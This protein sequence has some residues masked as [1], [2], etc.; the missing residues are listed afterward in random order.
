MTA[1]TAPRF[2]LATAPLDAGTVLL[3]ASA[4]TG[5]TYS[6]VGVLLRLLLEGHI[7]RLDR[8][9]VV[10]FTVAATAELKN[11]LRRGLLATLR[12]TRDGSDDEFLATLARQPDAAARVRAALADFDE[13][14]V[15][16]IHGF[17][18]RLL[19]DAAFESREPF[20]LEF[21]VDP[22]PLLHTAAADALRSCYSATSSLPGALLLHSG[23]DPTALVRQYSL[24]QR[25]P[26]VRFEPTAPALAARIARL[27]TAIASAV[28][29]FDDD[30]AARFPTLR[31]N[32]S[33][34]KA[35]AAI[36]RLSMPR[37]AERLRVDP[38]A[39]LAELCAMSPATIGSA[40][41][42]RPPQRLD[43]PFFAA[44]DAVRAATDDA[45]LHLRAEL[46]HRMHARLE[47]EKRQQQV[48]TFQDLL[49]RVHAALR[50][51]ER[52]PAL[53]ESVRSRFDV[54]LIDEFQDTDALQYEIFADCFAGRS[55]FLIGDPKQSIYGF[56]GADLDAYLAAQDDATARFT[57]GTNWRSA[58]GLVRAVQATCEAP[59][60]FVLDGIALPEITAHAGPDAL[61]LVGDGGAALQWRWLPLTATDD[62]GSI[63]KN[64]AEVRI[65]RD[66]AAEISRLLAGELTADGRPLS[67]R[68]IA[69]LTRTNAQAVAVQ[70]Q[71]RDAGVVSAIGK[72]GSVLE[73][74]ELDELERMLRAIL[75]PRNLGLC[76]AAMATRVFGLDAAAL[77]GLEQDEQGFEQQLER[78]EQ[79]RQ[80]WMRRGFVVM[81]EQLL[82]D[83]GVAGRWLALRGGER[84]LTNLQQLC[85]ILHRAEHEYRLSPE[86]LLEFLAHE[87]V[88]REQIDFEL[89]ELRLESDD[90]AVKILTVHGSKGLEYEV[91]F[92][93]F[94]WDGRSPA[95][96]AVVPGEQGRE[97]VFDL[98][99]SHP[100][101]LVADRERLAEDARLV[102]VALTR[103]KRRCY[104]HAGPIGFQ[105]GGMVRS[106]L[107]WMLAPLAASEQVDRPGKPRCQWYEDWVQ[108]SKDP[109]KIRAV[110]ERLVADNAEWMSLTD[111]EADPTPVPLTASVPAGRGRARRLGRKP[112]ARGLHSF[113]SLVAEALPEPVLRDVADPTGRVAPGEPAAPAGIFAFARGPAAGNCLHA[114]LEH[115]DWQ[116]LAD[117]GLDDRVRDRLREH[118]LL[119]PASHAAPIDPVAVVTANLRA[120]GRALTHPSGPPLAELCAGTTA[121]EWG[122][123]LPTDDCR[124]ATLAAT[125]A[126]GASPVAAAY[127]DRLATLPERTLRGHLVGFVDL[128]AEHDGRFW[129]I[130]WKSNH[131]GN[132][133][134]DYGDAALAGAMREHDY[135]LQYH[136]Y[137][138]ALHR[139]LRA[140]LPGY[141]YDRHFGG[142]CY[143][144]LRG[145]VP[146]SASGMFYDRPPAALV[147][148]LDG[149]AAGSAPGGDR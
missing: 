51:P 121:A 79:W 89:L 34:A 76:R 46:L 41:S 145:A 93:P 99:K 58:D 139:Q 49:T 6:V 103:A 54:G 32:Q 140:R 106:A 67:P 25:Y 95:R 87:R 130:D 78:F 92:C 12:A 63:R 53:L 122:F 97:L 71:L 133:V 72:A 55:L 29:A 96:E 22:L 134:E 137:V 142:V 14:P 111:V 66:V 143:A 83:L 107:L 116:R 47:A 91:V 38:H 60:A 85:E 62:K 7:D 74:D 19:D 82:A 129:V 21:A 112:F 68:D 110:L 147:E 100:S 120:L 5:K 114:I 10:T 35:V 109:D 64:I 141:D 13:V 61:Q 43:H 119:E 69:V 27:E 113:S 28:A 124:V 104:V 15:H 59:G 37:F 84:R 101:H 127:A 16:T 80:T 4:G 135:V 94:L 2:D 44:C 75:Q 24:W 128:V 9:L 11:R 88:H 126:A 30:F 52:R 131:L 118:A 149:W 8:A 1:A 73:T 117:D 36:G 56:R 20:G 146:G 39:V 86:G 90:D 123:T 81:K 77:A 48:V 45:T 144:F 18:K 65:A 125:F 23:F 42:R 105:G 31:F 98:L 115:L 17:C 70:D 33:A 26:D 108:R 138:L 136:L 50:D 40:L 102:Y 132:R 3:E 57:L 148:A